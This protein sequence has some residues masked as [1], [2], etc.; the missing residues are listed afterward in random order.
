MG[1]GERI[2]ERWAFGKSRVNVLQ[3]LGSALG[4]WSSYTEKW[5]DLSARAECE[6]MRGNVGDN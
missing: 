2:R 6:E 5:A 3:G 4:R 1:G